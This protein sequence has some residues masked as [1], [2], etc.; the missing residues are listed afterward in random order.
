MKAI[1]NGFMATM[2]KFGAIHVLTDDGKIYFDIPPE[3][4]FRKE[5]GDE[6][7]RKASRAYREILGLRLMKKFVD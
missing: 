3:S 7:L 2:I 4:E 1:Y 5:G 6:M